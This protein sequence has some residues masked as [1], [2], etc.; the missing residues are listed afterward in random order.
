MA[1]KTQ[2]RRDRG[3]IRH[4]R[5]ISV[6]DWIANAKCKPECKH[7]LLLMFASDNGIPAEEQSLLG[8]LAM[9]K[10][11][12]LDRYWTDT[13]LFRC[14]DGNQTLAERFEHHL[15]RKHQNTLNLSFRTRLPPL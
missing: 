1:A 14:K 13:E 15:N 12:G 9:V 6:G 4:A 11:G 2:R 10:G 7:A 8:F 3:S 5:G